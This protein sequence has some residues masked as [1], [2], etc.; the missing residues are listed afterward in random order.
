MVP[1]KSI[2]E[3]IINRITAETL[4]FATDQVVP[5]SVDTP[6]VYILVHS[7]GRDRTAVTKQNYEWIGS[8]TLTLVKVNEKGYISSVELDDL[9][10]EVCRIMDSIKI[11]GFKTNF[12]RF[13]DSLSDNLESP[14]NTINRKHIM[15]EIWVNRIVT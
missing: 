14:A 5:V 8:V 6:N 4:V 10:T 15:Y 1:D 2:R 7:Q 11:P 9:D 12:S 3:E 13:F